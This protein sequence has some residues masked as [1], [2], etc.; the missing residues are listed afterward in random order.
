MYPKI[1]CDTIYIEPFCV[2]RFRRYK[3]ISKSFKKTLEII[4]APKL[5]RL[6]LKFEVILKVGVNLED[7]GFDLMTLGTGGG[8]SVW[9]EQRRISGSIF[10]EQSNPEALAIL[11][12]AKS[13]IR[14]CKELESLEL[15]DVQ[16]E[17]KTW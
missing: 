13:E 7:F 5:P 17:K 4:H 6:E 16:L 15:S 3:K 14:D 9:P 2:T 12:K 8:F 10:A 1:S 11:E